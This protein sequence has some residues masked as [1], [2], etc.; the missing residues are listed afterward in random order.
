MPQMSREG[1]QVETYDHIAAHFDYFP[2]LCD[3]CSFS[4]YNPQEAAEHEVIHN[5]YVLQNKAKNNYV[6]NL[7]M[8]IYKDCLLASK[9]GEDQG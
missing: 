3:D 1:S 8:G 7:C 9:Y 4:C 6:D 5:H 2:H